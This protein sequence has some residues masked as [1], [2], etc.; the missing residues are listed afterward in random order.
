MEDWE[1]EKD[2]RDIKELKKTVGELTDRVRE[3]EYDRARRK[4]MWEAVEDIFH[5]SV[6]TAGIGLVVFAIAKLILK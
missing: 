2:K 1:R 6:L 4:G 5:W 3:L